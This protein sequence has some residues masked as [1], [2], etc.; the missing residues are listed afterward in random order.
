[1]LQEAS[2][3]LITI[4]VYGMSNDVLEYWIVIQEDCNKIV[5]AM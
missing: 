2:G 5:E 1:M 3:K 4:L